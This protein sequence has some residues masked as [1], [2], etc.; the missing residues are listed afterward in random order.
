VLLAESGDA[1]LADFGR[2]AVGLGARGGSPFSMS[3]SNSTT[4]RRQA[5]TSMHSVHWP[6]SWRRAIRRFIDAS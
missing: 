4:Q 3:R 1:L 5:T 6:T 2:V